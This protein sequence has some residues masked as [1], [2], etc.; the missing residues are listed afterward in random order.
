MCVSVC[1]CVPS[2]T[3]S[4]LYHE[5]CYLQDGTPYFL[6]AA[7]SLSQEAAIFKKEWVTVR[8]NKWA[9]T[10]THTH[11]DTHVCMRTHI[12][13]HRYTQANVICIKNRDTCSPKVSL[14]TT[15]TFTKAPL[16]F[17]C[18][19]TFMQ[20]RATHISARRHTHMHTH[21]YTH[22]HSHTHTLTAMGNRISISLYWALL[23]DW[24]TDLL[25]FKAV[26]E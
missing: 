6:I 1:Q 7:D 11:T 12:P 2:A 9:H 23:L 24:I 25:L 19:H 22:I 4:S 26:Y 5:G 21:T 8:A 14:A 3:L 13:I 18:S 17:V 16:T 20:Q 10:H 15:G